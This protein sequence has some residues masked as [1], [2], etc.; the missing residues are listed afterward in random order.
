MGGIKFLKNYVIEAVKLNKK[1]GSVVIFENLDFSVLS[2]EV[3]A[4]V[5]PSGCGKS[6]LFRCLIGLE[7]VEKGTITIDGISLVSDGK[8]CNLSDQSKIFS[9]IGVVFQNFELF[10]NLNVLQNLLI[11]ENDSSRAKSLLRRFGL[12]DNKDLFISNLSGGQK[13]RLAICRTLMRQPKVLL[14]DEPTSALDSANIVE[15]VKLIG[16]LKKDGYS[17]VVVT[18]DMK[19]VEELNCRVFELGSKVSNLK[20]V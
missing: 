2:S 6:T 5:G 18:H 3:V 7:K 12:M 1:F 9:K 14:F 15:I 17:V 20:N 8:Y 19:F 13:Q 16:E 4:V 10:K 11:V